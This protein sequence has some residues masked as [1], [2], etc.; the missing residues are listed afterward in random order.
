MMEADVRGRLEAALMEKGSLTP[1]RAAELLEAMLAEVPEATHRADL[2]ERMAARVGIPKVRAA[3]YTRIVVDALGPDM[4]LEDLRAAALGAPRLEALADAV[5]GDL[6]AGR[7][8]SVRGLGTFAIEASPLGRSLRFRVD[9]A[10]V[11][12]LNGDAPPRVD[13]DPIGRAAWAIFRALAAGHRVTIAGLGVLEVDPSTGKPIQIPAR[14]RPRFRAERD[15]LASLRPSPW[16]G[17]T[18]VLERNGPPPFALPMPP[19][20]A[21]ADDLAGLSSDPRWA[22]VE[23]LTVEQPTDGDCR[24][25]ASSW[26]P[27]LSVLRLVGGRVSD[28]G[29]RMLVGVGGPRLARLEVDDNQLTVAGID[30]LRVHPGLDPGVQRLPHGV[31]GRAELAGNDFRG[32]SWD[33]LDPFVDAWC[34]AL[35]DQVAELCARVDLA[36]LARALRQ[37]RE[38][39]DARE[40]W[41]AWQQRLTGS[42]VGVAHPQAA[43]VLAR[44]SETFD[45]VVSALIDGDVGNDYGRAILRLSETLALVEGTL[46]AWRSDAVPVIV[47]SAVAAR[48]LTDEAVAFI[49]ENR[50]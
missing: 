4:N 25:L 16:R 8:C 15:L 26:P 36:D 41:Q 19:S 11:G 50:N 28:A 34:G 46:G 17:K 40:R 24:L 3:L 37:V 33:D 45:R 23:E 10:L 35:V 12:A 48:R 20:E 22:T 32:I 29:A 30:A 31:L 47:P 21:V 7:E 13:L 1:D 14:R 2:A 9:D 39:D 5:R 43:R 6:A 27:S 44:V 49:R 18:L 38:L 42:A